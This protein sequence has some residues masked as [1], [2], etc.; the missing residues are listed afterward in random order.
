M[1]EPC[2]CRCFG[3]EKMASSIW[4]RVVYK[5]CALVIVAIPVFARVE[6][7]FVLIKK[8]ITVAN[9]GRLYRIGISRPLSVRHSPACLV[10]AVTICD[11]YPFDV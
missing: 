6:L 3:R 8:G 1:N 4:E 2:T 7:C 5:S 11:I 9:A 10:A